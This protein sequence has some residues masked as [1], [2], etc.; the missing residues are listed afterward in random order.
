MINPG[1]YEASNKA[2]HENDA[3]SSTKLRALQKSPAH[4]K[5][6]DKK[7]ETKALVI[8]DAFHA[9]ILEPMRFAEEFVVAA[10]DFNGRTKEGKAWKEAQG[11]KSVLTFD[12]GEL[13]KTMKSAVLANPIINKVLNSKGAPEVAVFWNDPD[14]GF[15]CKAKI[16]WLVK[17]NLVIELPDNTVIEIPTGSQIDLKTSVNAEYGFYRY[18]AQKLGYHIQ[19]AWYLYG[20][21]W[22]VYQKTG[23]TI[24]HRNFL[25]FVIEKEPPY[26]VQVFRLSDTLIQMGMGDIQKLLPLYVK[27]LEKDEWP[28]YPVGILELGA[29]WGEKKLEDMALVE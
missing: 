1:F 13:L 19:G 9:F 27:C 28:S 29:A 18:N 12:E 22:A 3:L 26:G 10:E 2:Y 5:A 24:E 25:H 16:D 11:D 7:K 20:A 15:P 21:D 8:G 14:Y 17:E 4:L 23:K 6:V